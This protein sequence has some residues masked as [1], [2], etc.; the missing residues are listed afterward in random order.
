M[1]SSARALS[2][3]IRCCSWPFS[4][5][6]DSRDFVSQQVAGVF[7]RAASVPAFSLNENAIGTGVIG[8]DVVRF[9]AHGVLS[10][11]LAAACYGGERPMSTAEGRT[12][13][14]STGSS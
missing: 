11:E 8:G 10:A 14:C 1:S 7:A 9:R 4:R 13:T 5:D 6:A 3:E 12:R 2:T